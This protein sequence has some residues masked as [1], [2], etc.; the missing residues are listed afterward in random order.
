[1]ENGMELMGSNLVYFRQ[2]QS[3]SM[4]MIENVVSLQNHAHFPHIS[5]SSMSLCY[6]TV[7]VFNVSCLKTAS[8]STK[9]DNSTD[10]QETRIFIQL[11]TDKVLCEIVRLDF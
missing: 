5:V 3:S 6:K 2:K 9:Q 1:M 11:K 7:R 4:L 8:R 10:V